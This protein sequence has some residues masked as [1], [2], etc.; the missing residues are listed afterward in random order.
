M[1]H[2]W[3]LRV[4]ALTLGAMVV[5]GGDLR[6]LFVIRETET[7]GVPTCDHLSCKRIDVNYETLTDDAVTV[8]LGQNDLVFSVSDDTPTGADGRTKLFTLKVV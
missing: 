5:N 7:V 3:I 6:P 1:H 2:Y 4:L 8:P